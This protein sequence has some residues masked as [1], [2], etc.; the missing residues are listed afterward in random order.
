MRA[1]N[2]WFND[3]IR[4]AR[5]VRRQLERKWMRSRLEVDRQ[6]FCKQ[7]RIVNKLVD[8]AKTAYYS[9]QVD[10]CKGDQGKLFKIVN[11]LLHKSKGRECVLPTRKSDREL[12]DKFSNYFY[13]KIQNIRGLFGP[14][15]DHSSVALE[16]S[17][18]PL[19]VFEP[20][21]EDEIKA[22]IMKSPSKSCELDPV[23]TFIIKQCV[24]AIVPHLTLIV[25]KSLQSGH[26]SDSLKVAHIR[27]LLKK[28]GL[29]IE[30]LKNY[31]PVSNL[32]YLGKTIERVVSKRMSEHISINNLSDPF[33]SAY[34]AHHG[35]ETAL[36]RVNNDILTA[37][38][39]GEITALILLDL[40][41]AFDTVDHSILLERLQSCIGVG[42]KGADPK[43]R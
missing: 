33:Q 31:R 23:P 11:T 1:S 7:R 41:A 9:A 24:D 40:S 8:K 2:P 29:D 3:E 16:A 39:N 22:V 6:E 13:E 18:H 27:P 10:D 4:S 15:P 30:N 12:A 21:S 5:K 26:F 38:D 19:S 17:L 32:T 34:K 37:L 25:N 20:A 14:S 28:T 35:T 43:R 42:G 36:L